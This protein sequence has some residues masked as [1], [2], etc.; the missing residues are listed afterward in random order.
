M[1][2]PAAAAAFAILI[3]ASAFPAAHA[4]EPQ[5]I[6]LRST[7]LS[8]FCHASDESRF[9]E[10]EF[11]GGFDLRA[12]DSDFGQLS[13]F[14]FLQPGGDFIGVADHGYWFF[15]TVLRDDAG[16]PTGFANF[17]M[18][19]MVGSD[20]EIIADKEHKDAEG[21]DI[22]EGIATV[23]FER[24]A[25][26][27][28]YAIDLDGMGPPLRDLDFVIPRNEL[29][30]NQGL[31]TVLRAHPN[32][33]HEGARIVIAERSIDR[34]GDIFAAFLE[35]PEKGIFKVKRSDGFDITDGAL[36]DNGDIL[37]LERRFS[38]ALGIAMRL[39]RIQGETVRRGGLADG[40]VVMEADLTCNIDNMEGM[41]VWRRQDGA[42]VVSLLSDNNQSFLQRT[43]YLEFVL[44]E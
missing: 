28:E 26:V 42:L 43:L 13:S 15:G 24:V 31:E 14:R 5:P 44:A 33:I 2:L 16:V 35:G 30:Y 21:L 6:E 3:C 11:V 29:R 36:L 40:P 27:S 18:Q 12:E 23:S 9:G 19:A 37:L 1:K 8:R 17:R 20:G 41:D 34:N 25:R 39:R 10:M 7:P 4:F 38:V 22:H 32:G